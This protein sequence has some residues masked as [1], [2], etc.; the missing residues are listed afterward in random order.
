MV[1]VYAAEADRE[2]IVRALSAL[3]NYE[4]VITLRNG[5]ETRLATINREGKEIPWFVG[6]E[7][8]LSYINKGYVGLLKFCPIMQKKCIGVE[9]ALY[10]VQRNCGDCSLFWVGLKE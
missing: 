8:T 3:G 6:L 7:N 5:N 10:I 2:Q 9:C 1:I 4:K